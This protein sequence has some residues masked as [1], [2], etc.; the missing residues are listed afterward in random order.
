MA[1]NL[2]PVAPYLLTRGRREHKIQGKEL[3][4]VCL[5]TWWRAGIGPMLI[6]DSGETSQ[7]A[8]G[9]SRS[10][11]GGST[12]VAGGPAVS[13]RVTKEE[14]EEGLQTHTHPPF[15]TIVKSPAKQGSL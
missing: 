8:R 7:R 2:G 9:D 13:A 14:R 10:L 5:K 11:P 3:D 15:L 6:T 1:L 12:W 4:S